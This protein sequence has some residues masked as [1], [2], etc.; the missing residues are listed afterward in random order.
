M[1]PPRPLGLVVALDHRL[2]LGD[3]PAQPDVGHRLAV[4]KMVGDLSGGPAVGLGRAPVQLVF[5]DPEQRV[6]DLVEP[7]SVALHQRMS[8]ALVHNPSFRPSIADPAR[9]P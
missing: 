8:F 5:G 3:Q 4:G 6:P 7:G 9:V 2:V 1:Q